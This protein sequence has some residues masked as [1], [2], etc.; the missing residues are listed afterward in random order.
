MLLKSLSDWQAFENS[1]SYGVSTGCLSDRNWKTWGLKM[2]PL[3]LI[4]IKNYQF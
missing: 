1:M 2:T 3:W 4:L